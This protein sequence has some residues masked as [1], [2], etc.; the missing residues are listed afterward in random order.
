MF[1]SKK[2]GVFFNGHHSS[3]FGLIAL[4]NK[5]VEMP[6]KNKVLV[7]LPFANHQLD[8]STIYGDQ[9][10][11]ERKYTQKFHLQAD[12]Y[13]KEGL[14]RLW[15]QV[16]NWLMDPATKTPLFDDVMHRYYYL[17]EVQK[18]PEYDEMLHW[19][20]LTV[21][22]TCYP[23]RI[24]SIPEGDDDWDTFDFDFDIAQDVSYQV[25]GM[26]TLSLYNVGASTADI[27]VDCTAPM[28][29]SI[30]G[31]IFTVPAGKSKGIP[32]F[33]GKNAVTVWGSGQIDF[34]FYKEL[35]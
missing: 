3:E 4:E 2:Y 18:P 20:T 15:T 31:K 9:V 27:V 32:L 23:F 29:I 35:I 7:D 22:W 13:D 10:Y 14:Y 11:K 25:D 34:I 19:G 16:V 6:E 30:G 5:K 21:E 24:S 28:T 26:A 1:D 8:L 33:K 17:A 12:Q